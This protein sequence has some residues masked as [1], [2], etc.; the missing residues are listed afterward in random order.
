MRVLQA[1]GE[2]FL[3]SIVDTAFFFGWGGVKRF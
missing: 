1:F 3:D 2:G